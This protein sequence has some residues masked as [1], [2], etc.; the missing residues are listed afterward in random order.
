MLITS[1]QS[2]YRVYLVCTSKVHASKPRGYWARGEVCTVCTSFLFSLYTCLFTP[3]RPPQRK[4][5]T[6]GTRYTSKPRG[7]WA[8]G[9]YLDG[10]RSV[11]AGHTM[12]IAVGKKHCF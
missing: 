1:G 2:V 3:R 12:G 9:V 10:T 5:G 4:K 6:Q 7:Y 11:H 8:R